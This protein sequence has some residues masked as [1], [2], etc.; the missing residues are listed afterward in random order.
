[1]KALI[2]GGGIGGLTTAIAFKRKGIDFEVFEAA[3]ELRAVGAGIWLGGN[4]MNVYEK[5]GMAGAIKAISFY[6]QNVFIKDYTGRI[7]QQVDNEIIRKKYGSGTQSIHRAALQQVLAEEISGKLNL[8]KKCTAI[9]QD[10]NGATIH[11][12][13]GTQAHGDFVVAADGIRSAIRENYVT[14]A[15]YRYSGQTCWRAIADIDLPEKEQ[16]KS[17]EV[18]GYAKGLR[19]S[20]SQVGKDQVYFWVTKAMPAGSQFRN[21]E[22]LQLI[23]EWL[24]PFRTGMMQTVIRNIQPERLIHSDLYDFKPVTKWHDGKIVL[25]GDAAHA[26]TPNL[27]QGASQAIEGAYVLAASLCNTHTPEAAFA[28]YQQKRIARVKKV[29]DTSWML[30]RMTNLGSPVL[31]KMRNWFIR[32]TPDFILQKQFDQLYGID[33]DS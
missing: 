30:A 13:D 24:E 31:R 16:R 27:G 5:L 21:P 10:A 19:A 20:Y 4:A 33:L 28:L 15:Q 8:G 7:L 14:H 3:P 32:A 18:W 17:S 6:Q 2:I 22:A 25:L 12:E 26:T 29:V 9:F 11:F 23:K 1:M